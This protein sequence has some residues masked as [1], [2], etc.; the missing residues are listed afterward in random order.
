MHWN[1]TK[2]LTLRVV[3][4]MS[5]LKHFFLLKKKSGSLAHFLLQTWPD[6]LSLISMF[7]WVHELKKNDI[8][9][10]NVFDIIRSF[11]SLSAIWYSGIF[12]I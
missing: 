4:M 7:K 9:V 3:T 12:I 2:T 1:C 6:N 11:Y 5:G 10:K 8:D